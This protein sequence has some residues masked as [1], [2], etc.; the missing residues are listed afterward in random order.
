MGIGSVRISANSAEEE[1]AEESNGEDRSYTLKT[2]AKIGKTKRKPA[3]AKSSKAKDEEEVPTTRGTLY[4]W[5]RGTKST[6][7]KTAKT[8]RKPAKMK[9]YKPKSE[10]EV[11][12]TRGTLYNWMR[13]AKSTTKKTAKTSQAPAAEKGS[14]TKRGTPANSMRSRAVASGKS[15]PST[16]V[17]KISSNGKNR[18]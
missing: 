9:A 14:S 6:A 16:K 7:N 10:E 4:N 5:M 3:K 15:R 13:G 2:A 11:P 18:G 1:P 8:R 12:A 17:R